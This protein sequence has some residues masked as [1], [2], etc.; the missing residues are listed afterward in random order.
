MTEMF[1]YRIIR[2]QAYPV[3]SF[4]VGAIRESPLHLDSGSKPAGMTVTEIVAN[5]VRFCA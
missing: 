2:G 1:P 4:S 5:Q 3:S